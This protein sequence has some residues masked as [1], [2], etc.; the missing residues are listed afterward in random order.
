MMPKTTAVTDRCYRRAERGNAGGNRG[1]RDDLTRCGWSVG[2]SRGPF[3]RADSMFVFSFSVSSA[4]LRFNPLRFELKVS[5][6]N[7]KIDLF[8]LLCLSQAT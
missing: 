1:I 5:T 4:P 7:I 3:A 8:M 6:Q 2:H